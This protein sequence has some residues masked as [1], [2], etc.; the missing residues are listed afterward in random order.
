MRSSSAPFRGAIGSNLFSGTDRGMGGMRVTKYEPI[1]RAASYEVRSRLTDSRDCVGTTFH[2]RRL[3]PNP[4]DGA[5]A[6]RDGVRVC[7]AR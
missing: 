2:G 4:V 1:P 6:E 7:L 5:R 3:R